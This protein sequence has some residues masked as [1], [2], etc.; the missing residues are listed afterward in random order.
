MSNGGVL[1]DALNGSREGPRLDPSTGGVSYSRAFA[2]GPVAARLVSCYGRCE[3]GLLGGPLQGCNSRLFGDGASMGPV[4]VAGH[5]P[6]IVVAMARFRG[7][8]ISRR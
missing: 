4:T 7:F 8:A 1:A 2:G 5:A 3:H 6:R